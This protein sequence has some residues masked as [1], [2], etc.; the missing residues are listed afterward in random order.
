M[1]RGQ[2]F[3]PVSYYHTLTVCRRWEWLGTG[4]TSTFAVHECP[5][6]DDDPKRKPTP[7]KLQLVSDSLAASRAILA[8]E[9]N[10]NPDGCCE[11]ARV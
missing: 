11:G 8:T 10:G 3:I 5:T 7:T 6:P 9:D 2:C 1:G 4:G